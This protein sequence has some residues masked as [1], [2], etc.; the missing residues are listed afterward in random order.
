M[1]GRAVRDGGKAEE[2]RGCDKGVKLNAERKVKWWNEDL[3][4]LGRTSPR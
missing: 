2:V 1:R 4:G 3:R